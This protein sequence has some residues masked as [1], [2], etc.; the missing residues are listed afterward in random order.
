MRPGR[1]RDVATAHRRETQAIA[2]EPLGTLEI[3]DGK[4]DILDRDNRGRRA[5]CPPTARRT[6][7]TIVVHRLA[8]LQTT[9]G[10][11]AGSMQTLLQMICDADRIGDDREGR[12]DRGARAE[13]AGVDDVEIIDL[14][15][16]AIDVKRRALGIIARSARCRSDDLWLRPVSACRNRPRAGPDASLRSRYAASTDFSLAVRR[17]C[18]STVGRRVVDVDAVLLDSHPVVRHRQV[19]RG[20]PEIHRMASH[21]V[22]RPL[23][24]QPMS[25]RP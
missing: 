15:A 25:S 2:I 3:S 23:G 21:L 11:G 7:A 9:G 12:I 16:A 1:V 5:S 22:E 19:L 6:M 14:V 18:A 20:Q 10:I 24:Q 4:A 8:L 17:S 13:K